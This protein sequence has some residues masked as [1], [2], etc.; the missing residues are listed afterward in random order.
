MPLITIV[1]VLIVVGVVLWLINTYSNAKRDQ[2]DSERSGRNRGSGL[3]P[4]SHGL[5]GNG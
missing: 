5:M 3:G 1:L 4:A 2:N